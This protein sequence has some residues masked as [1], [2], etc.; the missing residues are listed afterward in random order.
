MA[1]FAKSQQEGFHPT[2]M[3]GAVKLYVIFGLDHHENDCTGVDFDCLGTSVYNP[4]FDL[5]TAAAQQAIEVT[6]T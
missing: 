5:S 3:D 2:D 4:A 6:L 1:E